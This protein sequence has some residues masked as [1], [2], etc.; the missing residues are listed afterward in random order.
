M[1][2]FSRVQV[3]STMEQIGMV[4]LFYNGDVETSVQIAGALAAGGA[5]VIEFTN[6]GDRAFEV[7]REMV[8]RL[9]KDHPQVILGVGSVL[10]PATAGLYINLGA[11][12]IVGSVTNPGSPSSATAARSPISPD[13]LR[14]LRYRQPRSWVARSSRSFPAASWAA[15][16]L[17]KPSRR[18]APGPR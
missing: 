13:A 12:F 11:N 1:A 14:H 8:V 7:F 3:W 18:P 16:A 4:P 9:E 5:R 10:D 17:S 15:P 6:R 2:R